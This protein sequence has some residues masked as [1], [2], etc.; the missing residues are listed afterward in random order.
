MRLLKV[1]FALLVLPG[2]LLAQ[3]NGFQILYLGAN[4][5]LTWTNTY[6]NGL[7]GIEW[8]PALTGPW[9]DNWTALKSMIVTGQIA[10]ADVPMFYRV[11]CD[12]NLFMPMPM[13]A[14]LEMSV[15]NA[16]GGVW[17][18]RM[19]VAGSVFL[20]SKG[21]EFTVLEGTTSLYPGAMQTMLMRST[22]NALYSI[23]AGCG[24]EEVAMTNAPVGTSWTNVVCGEITV[25]T[26]EAFELVTVPLGTFNCLRVRK[27][28]LNTSH[29][30]PVWI[31]WWQPGVG[32]IQWV[33]YYV[34]PG[35]YPPVVHRLTARGLAQ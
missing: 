33:D 31:E 25:N 7:Y 21:K 15:S 4:G 5:R 29:T 12:T 11:K 23:A 3:G 28:Q 13:G 35:E 27:Q 6:P 32:Q 9:Q 17:T 14:Y 1:F 34:E 18:E 22:S 26:I 10:A 8:A 2:S 16:A 30:N 19:T 24:M 20:P